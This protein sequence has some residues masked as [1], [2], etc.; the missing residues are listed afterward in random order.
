ME[1][2]SVQ[3]MKIK[4]NKVTD[5]SLDSTRRMLQMVEESQ[6]E[7]KTTM[8]MLDK[9]GQQL[10]NAEV[11]MDEI[12]E[13]VKTA[14]RNLNEMSKCCGWCLC[15]CNRQKSI[16]TNQRYKQVRGT[17][18]SDE[19][20]VSSQVTRGN[21]QGVTVRSTASSGPYIKRITN[22]AQEKELEENLE[23]VGSIIGNLKNMAI[24]INNE[25][26]TQNKTIDRI[27]VKE[28]EESHD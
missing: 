2:M 15:S 11:N 8:I 12:M 19:G 26:D 6:G 13:N 1:D 4:M 5:K 22:D 16:K 21:T 18:K 9:Q 25:L 24:D 20:V 23:Q 17:E 7:G 27:T 10:R 28:V 3:D 14:E